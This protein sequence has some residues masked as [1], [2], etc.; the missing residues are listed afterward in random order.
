LVTL[1]EFTVARRY[2]SGLAV[3]LVLSLL[4]MSLAAGWVDLLAPGDQALADRSDDAS[5]AVDAFVAPTL[6]LPVSLL[7]L[8]PLFLVWERL[9]AE[10]RK[11]SVCFL[12][13][14]E[15]PRAPPS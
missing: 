5:V 12:T 11:A 10:H 6:A 14:I 1:G 9:A 2:W 3:L 13:P 7:F 4:G 8:A 15:I